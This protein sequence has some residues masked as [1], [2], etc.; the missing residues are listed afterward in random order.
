[1][2]GLDKPDILF[3]AWDDTIFA[4]VPANLVLKNNPPKPWMECT[5]IAR[6]N[7]LIRMTIKESFTRG[8]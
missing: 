8:E 7:S 5:M 3:H 4:L 1:M 2:T 6:R